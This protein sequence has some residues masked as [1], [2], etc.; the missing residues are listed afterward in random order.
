[1]SPSQLWTAT[2]G[3]LRSASPTRSAVASRDQP[4][5]K[6]HF[7]GMSI[8]MHICF[9]IRATKGSHIALPHIFL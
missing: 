9:M 8:A 6:P 1:M 7:T 5:K 4:T 2:G 3:Q